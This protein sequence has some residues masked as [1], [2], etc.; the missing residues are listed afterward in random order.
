ML[1][2]QITSWYLALNL[3]QQ[4]RALE[5]VAEKEAQSDVPLGVC[6]QSC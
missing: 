3:S 5:S 2:E 6:P 1:T 4:S